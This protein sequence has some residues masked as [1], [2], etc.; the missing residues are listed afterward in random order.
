MYI[1]PCLGCQFLRHYFIIYH[2]TWLWAWK[3][4]FISQLCCSWLWPLCQDISA[5]TDPKSISLQTSHK[6]QPLV[7]KEINQFSKERFFTWPYF[8]SEGFE[9]TD[10]WPSVVLFELRLYRRGCY[11]QKKHNITQADCQ[12]W[13]ILPSATITHTVSTRS[14]VYHYIVWQHKRETLLTFFIHIYCIS[15]TLFSSYTTLTWIG[16]NMFPNTLQFTVIQS[17]RMF[18]MEF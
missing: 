17:E 7:P 15:S 13:L 6:K 8:E 14:G 5:V 12:V 11:P 2:F 4:S 3:T 9:N 10:K 16:Y 18:F 1:K